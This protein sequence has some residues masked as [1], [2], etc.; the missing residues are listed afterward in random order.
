[1]DDEPPVRQRPRRIL[2]S[3]LR[4]LIPTSIRPVSHDDEFL[5]D[6]KTKWLSR[7]DF[8][9]DTYVDSLLLL[10]Y[11]TLALGRERE[12]EWTSDQLIRYVHLRTASPASRAVVTSALRLSAYLKAQRGLDVD[13]LLAR[14][15]IV[16]RGTMQR[17][18]EWLSPDASY[19]IADAIVREKLSYL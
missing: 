14:A 19:E 9:S 5:R 3:G 2:R 8:A 16:S 1:N 4:E 12:A 17:D 6:Y 11:M 7:F 15:R 10:A 13:P 18:R